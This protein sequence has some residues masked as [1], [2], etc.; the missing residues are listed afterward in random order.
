MPTVSYSS[1]VNQAK[2][3]GGDLRV[4]ACDALRDIV[5]RMLYSLYEVKPDGLR[6]RDELPFD[7]QNEPINWDNLACEWVSCEKGD[8]GTWRHTVWIEETG[9]GCDCLCNWVASHLR[10]WGWPIKE[11]ITTW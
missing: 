3:L 4:Y 2:Y 10:S 7:G 8:D 6:V 5:N 9:R 1:V 11:V